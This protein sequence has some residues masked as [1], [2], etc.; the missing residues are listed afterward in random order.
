MT[1]D[2]TGG[3]GLGLLL[4]AERIAQ[5]LGIA[6]SETRYLLREGY[7]PGHKIGARW[8]TTRGELRDSVRTAT[9]PASASA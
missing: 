2:D 8:A 9:I 5:E 6:A 1:E 4:G 7:L 3:Y